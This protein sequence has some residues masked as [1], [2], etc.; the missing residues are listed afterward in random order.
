MIGLALVLLLTVSLGVRGMV[1][2][3]PAIAGKWFGPSPAD[4]ASLTVS[5]GLGAM[6]GGVWMLRRGTLSAV[7]GAVLAGPGG[8]V[9]VM[10]LFAALAT[11]LGRP[12]AAGR[13]RLFLPGLG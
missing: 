3:L 7:L 1:E 5:V 9:V 13:H 6:A 4:L 11:P 8:L 10:L 12:C 2:L